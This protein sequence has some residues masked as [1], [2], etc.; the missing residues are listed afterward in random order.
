MHNLIS[1]YGVN[2]SIPRHYLVFQNG[3]IANVNIKPYLF[4]DSVIDYG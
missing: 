3:N 2:L 4:I 1:R